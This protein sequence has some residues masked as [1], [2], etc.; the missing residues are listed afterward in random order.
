MLDYAVAEHFPQDVAAE[1]CQ[2]G[3]D[4]QF[5]TAPYAEMTKSVYVP[6]CQISEGQETQDAQENGQCHE[7]AGCPVE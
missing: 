6:Y 4:E 3:V 5:R 1:L 2:C 7:Q